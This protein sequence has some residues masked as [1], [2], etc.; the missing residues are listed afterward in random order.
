MQ[1]AGNFSITSDVSG[2]FAA[3]SAVA[4][5]PQ[6]GDPNNNAAT[7][8]SAIDRAVRALGDVQANVGAAINT[9]GYAASLA[10]SQITNFSA[11]RS[12]IKDANMA[13]AATDLFKQQ[14]LMEAA[15]FA[16]AQSN[17]EPGSVLKLLEQS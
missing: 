12:Q 4:N 15:I 16:F 11:A 17:Q 8:I 7:A 3:G 5:A 13:W 14:V 6:A 10:Q 9:L 1:S 2:A